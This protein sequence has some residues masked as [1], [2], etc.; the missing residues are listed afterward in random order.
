MK[1]LLSGILAGTFALSALFAAAACASDEE[2]TEKGDR[3][4]P[5]FS[6]AQATLNIDG[7]LNA[8]GVVDISDDIFG[9]FLED[10]NY[11]SYV[12]SD[13]MVD[14]G[15]FESI[16]KTWNDGWAY[17]GG[18]TLASETS[19][20]VLKNVSEYAAKNVNAHYGRLSIPASGGKLENLG[21]AA[22]PIAVKQGVDYVFSAFFRSP[23]R[24][25]TV[26]VSV[27]DGENVYLEQEFTVKQNDAW[28]KYQRTI[29]ATGTAS[30][31]LKL[32]LSFTAETATTLYIDAVSFETTDATVGVKNYIWN[33]IK[34][35]SPKF[36]RFPGGCVVEGNGSGG[37]GMSNYYDWKNSVGAVVTGTDAGDDDVPAVQY[38]LDTDGTPTTV[39]KRGEPFTRTHN[40]DIWG[41]EMDYAIGFFDFF[42]L[43]ES[44]GAS[45]VPVL[46]CGLSCQG[47]VPT[48]KGVKLAGRH[49]KG[50]ADFVQ[51]ALDLVEF[52]KGGTDTKWGAIRAALG[53]EAPFKMNYIGIGNEQSEAKY[54]I[55]CYEQFLLPFKQA[56]AQHPEVY[57][58]VQIIVGN[59]T[60]FGDCENPALG[61]KGKAQTAAE[62]YYADTT[63]NSDGNGGKVID[64]IAGYGVHDHHYYR[65]YLDFFLHHDLYDRYTRGSSRSYNVFVGEY[66]ANEA[67]TLDGEDYGFDGYEW[68][69]S[70]ITALSEAAMM[71]GFERNG[72]VVQLAAYAP[73][74]APWSGN[75]TNGK[76]EVADRQWAVDMMYFTNT[77]LTLTTNYYVQQLFMNNAG[78]KL[79]SYDAIQYANGFA[80]T[81]ALEGKSAQNTAVSHEIDKLY[82]VA[83]VD[84][85]TGD[86]IVKIVNASPSAVKI[87][88]SLKN[89]KLTGLAH[90]TVLQCDDY[91]AYNTPET[92]KVSPEKY[93]IDGF[94]DSSFGYEAKGYSVAAFRVH[95]K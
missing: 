53:H 86:I 68:R 44:V 50:V 41:Y 81:Y 13:D 72:D 65:N 9:A 28:I 71:T 42:M 67:I 11:A 76:G 40:R 37:E 78:T 29:P 60:Q 7:D 10:I 95:V 20:G 93:T 80:E 66:S 49:E 19:N 59:A 22:V 8:A 74:F 17:S 26:K 15:S 61:T 58:D 6:D 57:G 27:T 85:A 55:D 38:L 12:M 92:T 43:C 16:T 33:A 48:E 35:L 94:T 45:A 5:A 36:I 34:Q 84:E 31:D 23:D 90:T 25:V 24:D 83:S 30:E 82:Y 14:N 70:W 21:Y 64:N 47:G 3:Q 2:P 69:N 1:K 46:N 62:S 73:M 52:A 63:R 56:R 87:N 4:A 39:T 54:Y 79:L 91:K 18:A 77:E 75:I 88:V 32:Q 89:A 51:D